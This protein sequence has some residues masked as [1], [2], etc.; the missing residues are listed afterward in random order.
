MAVAL[1]LLGGAGCALDGSA[2]PKRANGPVRDAAA[3]VSRLETASAK[4]DWRTVCDDLFTAGARSRA[5]GRDCPRLLRSDAGS[6]SKPRIEV[7]R[8]D[9]KG[10]RAAVR[11]RSRAGG[12]PPLEDV[13]QLRRERGS[14]RIDSLA[15]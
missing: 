6:L 3:V 11:V 7:V 5:G 13:I 8:I 2:K 10:P 15:G 12:Q 14:F 1:A 4:G 9:V